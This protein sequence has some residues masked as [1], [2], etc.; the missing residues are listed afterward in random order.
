MST[1][2]NKAIDRR[3]V[4]GGFNTG[5][6][7]VL[8]E[9]I[10]ADCVDHAAPPGTPSG[11]EGAKQFFAM[12]RSA[13]PDLHTTIEDVVAEGDK[14]VTRSTWHGT[15][16]GAFLGIPA[17]GKQVAVT[18]IDITRYAGGKVV[19]HWGNQDLLGLMQQLGVIPA[20]GQAS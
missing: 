2:E 19:E 11:R 9:F 14:V 4:E 8:D 7:A 16:R 1:E 5:N 17:T 13:F 12:L 18:Q 3:I 10:A 20:P 15:H 6:T